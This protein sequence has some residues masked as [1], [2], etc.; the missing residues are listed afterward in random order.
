MSQNKP[1]FTRRR[2]LQNTALGLTAAS[3]LGALSSCGKREQIVIPNPMPTRKLGRTGLDVSVLS[4]GGGSQ[5][6]KNENDVWEAMLE[7]AIELGINY[8]DTSSGYQWGA[9]MT[10][11]ERFGEILPKYREK[12]ILSSKFEKRDVAECMK[13]IET[14]LKRMKTDYFD[15]LL[16][17]SIEESEDIAAFEKGMYKEM[18]KLKEEGTARHIGFSS[19]NSSQKSKELIEKLDLDMC[20][21]AMNP[22]KYG[23]FAQVALPT[24]DD[25]NIGVVAMKVMR[26]IVGKDA[27]PKEL[28]TYALS[29]KGVASA[30]LGHIGIETLEENAK[31]AKEIAAD[32]TAF[33]C[34]ALEKRLA[35]LAGPHVLCW[36]RPDYYDGMMC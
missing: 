32:Q 10:S 8:F 31:L 29:Q 1:N 23:D 25:K 17:H 28:L 34:K 12:I 30:V 18:V 24:A 6:L 22:T 36:A 7:R 27:T 2:F 9:S 16:V 11:E 14:S 13:E 26:D 33:D 21:L 4:F 19:M 15:I 35:H 5:F 3:G 20:I